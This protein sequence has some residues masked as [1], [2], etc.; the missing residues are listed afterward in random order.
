M[1][2]IGDGLERDPLRRLF[3]RFILFDLFVIPG[4]VAVW[5]G[6]G[7]VEPRVI[8][9]LS[10][11]RMVAWLGHLYALSRP[12]RAAWPLDEGV[13]DA[14]VL[15][16]DHALQALVRRAGRSYS[17]GWCLVELAWIFLGAF[18]LPGGVSYGTA[19]L[20]ASLLFVAS[21]VTLANLVGMLLD[22]SLLDLRDRISVA[23]VRRQLRARRPPTSITYPLISTAVSMMLGSLLVVGACALVWVA[24]IEREHALLEQQSRVELAEARF[25]A[26][27]E[28]P[29]GV[30]V[31]EREALPP[32][33]AAVLEQES[34]DAQPTLLAA[35]DTDHDLALAAAP[36]DRAH[37]AL[38]Q[39]EPQVD[40]RL[41]VGLLTLVSLMGTPLFAW[42]FSTF[43]RTIST[44]LERFADAAKQ[45]AEHGEL[46]ALER[47]IP[48]RNDEL[49]RLAVSFNE[50]LDTLEQLTAAAAAVSAGKL[51]VELDHPGE[52]H[53]AFRGMLVRLN[54][55]VGRLRETSL[56]VA[57][58]ASEINALTAQ[59]EQA[60]QVQ[61]GNIQEVVNT[62]RSLATSAQEI[63]D[64]AKGVRADAEQALATT[65]LT[66]DEI[67]E[68][69]RHTASI[70]ELLQLIG[71][72][73]ER[74]DLLALNGSLEATRAGEAGRGFALVAAEMRR[75]AERVSGT[76]ELVRARIRSIETS[77]ASTVMATEQSRRLAQRTAAAARDISLVT[78]RQSADTEQASRG[79]LAVA[80]I[81]GQAAH[82]T[83]QTRAAAEG[84]HSWATELERLLGTFEIRTST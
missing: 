61:S 53:D 82:A 44:P 35:H 31:V 79:V 30:E 60:S 4:M 28:L 33:L 16:A 40:L 21:G 37:W 83:S 8:L 38:S 10:V 73:A 15:E 6:L 24:Q 54:E 74:S 19:E 80:E 7:L 67:A 45:F 71:E 84:L 41:F 50:M 78:A 58:A 69:R 23:I 5:A 42:G 11:V 63:A 68:L 62:V 25:A 36:L 48:L 27:L 9:T 55:I 1:S 34:A 43:A 18:D 51:S 52:L 13:P 47:I 49:G 72:V 26:G 57:S 20:L 2:P 64:A 75:L 29:S 3:A 65:D 59:Q 70:A 17:A 76:V 46:Q 56:E 66:A 39:A 22:V 12:I 81:V 32:A 77:G 14:A